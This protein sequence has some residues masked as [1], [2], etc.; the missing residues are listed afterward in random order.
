[1]DI[2]LILIV[3]MTSIIYSGLEAAFSRSLHD[4]HE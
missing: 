3:G 2:A 4:F 1:M